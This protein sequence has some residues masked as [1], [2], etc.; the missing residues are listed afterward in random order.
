M[1]I[2]RPSK[3]FIG[4]ETDMRDLGRYVKPDTKQVFF[5]K[6][7]NPEGAWLYFLP[8]YKTDSAG[9]GVWFKVFRIRDNFGD[10]LKDKYAVTDSNDPVEYFERNFKLNYPDDA[11]PVDEQNEKGQTRKRYPLCGRTTTRVIYNVAFVNGEPPGVHVLDLPSYNGA[12]IINDWLKGRDKRNNERPMLNDP[13]HCIPVFIKL[14]DTGGAPWQIEPEQGDASKL[15]DELA[16]SNN[17]YDLDNVFIKKSNTELIDKLRGLYPRDVF[18]KCM[19]GYSGYDPVEVDEIPMIHAPRP[20]LV[21]K[22]AASAPALASLPNEVS[23]S[24][25][26]APLIVDDDSSPATA[27]NVAAYLRRAKQS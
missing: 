6:K 1:A 27:A 3:K 11:R 21:K 10:K 8:A 25:D 19:E 4:S 20:S 14:K 9:N 17:L 24:K 23:S 7:S 26:E 15:P 16:D 12:S 13:D 2:I 18:E 22:V 5:S